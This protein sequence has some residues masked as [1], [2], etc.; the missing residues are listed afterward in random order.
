[1]NTYTKGNSFKVTIEKLL[2]GGDALTHHGSQVCFVNDVI[3][4]ENVNV[5]VEEVKKQYLITSPVQILSSSTYRTQPSCPLFKTCGGCQWQHIEYEHQLYWKKEIV[6]ECLAR[7]AGITNVDIPSPL[8]SPEILYYRNR[9]RL[10]VKFKGKPEIGFHKRKSHAIIPVDNCALL[11]PSLN[12]AIKTC[13]DILRSD[14]TL[15]KNVSGIDMLFIHST[16]QVL[17]SF[18]HGKKGG[19]NLLRPGKQ[20]IGKKKL[21]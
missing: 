6:K 18:L 13:H 8:P 20:H 7:I 1:M 17:M 14:Y 15:Y 19:G 10:Q 2:Y 12:D 9:A 21:P 16:G 4:G 5:R 3:P 11:I